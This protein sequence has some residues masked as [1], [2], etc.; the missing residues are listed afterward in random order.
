MV[1]L[2]SVS[3]PSSVIVGLHNGFVFA[4]ELEVDLVLG[5]VSFERREVDVKVEAACVS[6][7]TLN[8]GTESSVQE[9]SG[10]PPPCTAAMV[11]DECD[12]IGFRAMSACLGSVVDG[13]SFK[14]L[15]SMVVMI[16]KRRSLWVESRVHHWS[17]RWRSWFGESRRIYLFGRFAPKFWKLQFSLHI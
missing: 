9:A 5:L 2:L 1:D 7:G 17:Y 12:R 8:E 3:S 11:V 13:D 16:T 10:G 15:G 14:R 4:N 6:S